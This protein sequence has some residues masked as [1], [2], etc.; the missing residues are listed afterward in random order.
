MSKFMQSREPSKYEELCNTPSDINLHLPVLKRYAE[1]C[2]H[3]TEFGVR[4]V[5]STYAFIE[6]NPKVIRSYDINQHPNMKPAIVLAKSKGIDLKFI[7]D[8]T[9]ETE[10][11]ETDLLF[12]DT[13][14]TG[15]QIAKELALHADKVK[16]FLG[17]HDVATF[18]FTDERPNLAR[19]KYPATKAGE[20]LMP[21]IEKFLE[22]KHGEW[23]VDYFTK[24]NNGL[25][26]LKRNP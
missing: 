11:E 12:I 3:V 22:E 26:I 2:G 8:D 5:V 25:M 15:K 20:G 13:L 19:N 17:F 24:E 6:G 1:Q 7:I 10:M 9:L 14:H 4:S 21:V 23:D 18:G 16:L